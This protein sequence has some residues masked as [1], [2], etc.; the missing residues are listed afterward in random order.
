MT[1]DN[2]QNHFLVVGLS[3]IGVDALLSSSERL[4]TRELQIKFK[5][6][7]YAFWNEPILSGKDWRLRR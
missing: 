5:E 6:E 1:D 3:F 7:L 4:I 2:G